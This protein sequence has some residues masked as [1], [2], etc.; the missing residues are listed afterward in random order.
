MR[1]VAF[2]M[3]LIL[4][5]CASTAPRVQ[6][7][8]V[9]ISVP[10]KVEAPIRPALA[11]DS[12]PIGSGIWE[13]MKALRAERSQRQGYEAELEAAVKSC[14][15]GPENTQIE[16]NAVQYSAGAGKQPINRKDMP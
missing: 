5:G 2:V 15:E 10:C 14:Q 3:A 8:L 7:V 16:P 6:E 1:A 4:E 12:L 9:P 13:Q 11:V